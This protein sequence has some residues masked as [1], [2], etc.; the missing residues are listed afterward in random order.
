MKTAEAIRSSNRSKKI[1]GWLSREATLLIALIDE[2]QKQNDYKGDIFEIGVHHGK[3]AVLFSQFLRED[4]VLDVCDIFDD[5]SKNKSNSGDG[6][7]STFLKNVKTLG[8][9]K[10]GKIYQ[11]LSCDLYRE[12]LPVNYRIFHIDGGHDTEEALMDLELAA[13]KIIDSGVIILDD[14]FRQDWPGVTEA[15]VKFLEKKPDFTAFTVGFNKLMICRKAFAEKYLAIIDDKSQRQIFQLHY[16]IIFE[17]KR[18]GSNTMRVFTIKTEMNMRSLKVKVK[19][20]L[21]S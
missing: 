20:M 4:E 19:R 1:K 3:S 12:K 7:K 15:L 11:M 5:Q 13:D 21:K 14:P 10:I 17:K 18:F 8:K 6:N 9:N 2:V 16:P